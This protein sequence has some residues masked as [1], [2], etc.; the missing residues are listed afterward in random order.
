MKDPLKLLSEEQIA[1]IRAWTEE[2]E[3][4][5]ADVQS[6]I[7]EHFGISL[8]YM[9]SQ[10]L[11]SDLELDF[12]QSK[13]KAAVDLGNAEQLAEA[14]AEIRKEKEAAGEEVT[15]EDEP[16]ASGVQVSLDQVTPPLF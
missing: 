6:R 4:R 11:A 12:D 13:K 3:V 15:E 9:E 1:Q 16:E 2:D 14:K 5:L 7:K 8:T 10:F